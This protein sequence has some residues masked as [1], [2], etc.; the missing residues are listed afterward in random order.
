MSSILNSINR[1]KVINVLKPT[2]LIA[3]GILIGV[4]IIIFL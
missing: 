2:A 1:K 3:L 4:G